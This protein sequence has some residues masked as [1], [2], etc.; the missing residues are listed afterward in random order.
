MTEV[1]VERDMSRKAILIRGREARLAGVQA[2]QAE[3]VELRAFRAMTTDQRVSVRKAVRKGERDADRADTIAAYRASLGVGPPLTLAEKQERAAAK[4]AARI[5]ARE[6]M[7]SPA[8]RMADA[9]ANQDAKWFEYLD[10]VATA[11]GFADW[12]NVEQFMDA[13]FEEKVALKEGNHNASL[14]V[15]RGNVRSAARGAASR[16]GNVV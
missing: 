10:E 12:Y 9:Q 16:A 11:H 1:V 5:A 15:S 4:A 2:R 7:V 3:A 13:T 8:Q 14:L 6:A